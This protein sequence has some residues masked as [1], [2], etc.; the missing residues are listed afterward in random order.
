MKTAVI[1]RSF[2]CTTKQYA[3]WLKES[4]DCDILVF[5]GMSG[6]KL[7]EY[8]TVI[9]CSAAYAGWMP[10]IGFLKK[11]WR[12]LKNKKVIALAI[13]ISPAGNISSGKFFKKMPK[14]IEK[15]VKIFKIPD[16]IACSQQEK[17]DSLRQVIRYIK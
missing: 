3:Q 6:Q 10:L 14:E 12:I 17:K 1:F 2:F 13:G 11:W 4:L 9:V 16:K 7:M 8:N 15:N 5:K